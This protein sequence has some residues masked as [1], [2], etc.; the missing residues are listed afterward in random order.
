MRIMWMVAAGLALAP[1]PAQAA[2]VLSQSQVGTTF[3]VDF[4]GAVL[5]LI[6]QPNLGATGRFTFAGA[7][8]AGKT[9][10]FTYALTNDSTVASQIRSFGLDVVGA[11]VR[12]AMSTG[13]FATNSINPLSGLIGSDLCFT[14]STFGTCGLLGNS[15][16]TMGQ[17]GVGTFALTFANAME[18]IALDDFRVNYTGVLGLYGA[19]GTGDITSVVGQVSAAPEPTTWLTMLLGFTFVGMAMRRRGRSGVT[20]P[21]SA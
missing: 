13:A 6:N 21:R 1:M 3:N 15:T 20:Y 2:L 19:T 11:S 12:T 8:D 17:T 7:T 16:V 9:F 5:G 18:S 4:G 10:N 14:P